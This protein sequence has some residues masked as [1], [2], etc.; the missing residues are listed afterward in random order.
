MFYRRKGWLRREYDEKLLVEMAEYKRVW[1][2]Q[3]AL[4]EKCVEPT[5]ELVLET[6]MAEVKYFSLFKEAKYRQVKIK[7]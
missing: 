6:K 1:L 2:N 7:R 4:L 3:K 5:T